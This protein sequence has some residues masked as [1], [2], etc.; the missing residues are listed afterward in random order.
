MC[1]QRAPENLQLCFLLLR[2]RS[3]YS[4][5]GDYHY[6]IHELDDE[7]KLATRHSWTQPVPAVRNEQQRAR[8]RTRAISAYNEND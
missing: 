3:E 7:K 8:K 5:S 4:T 1:S 6:A 2:L